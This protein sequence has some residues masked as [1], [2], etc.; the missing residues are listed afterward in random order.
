MVD[1]A[2]RFGNWVDA[3]SA[4]LVLSDRLEADV[5]SILCPI[6]TVPPDFAGRLAYV[7]LSGSSG[8]TCHRGVSV[9]RSPNCIAGTCIGGADYVPLESRARFECVCLL[10]SR[11][12]GCRDHVIISKVVVVRATVT[13]PGAVTTAWLPTIAIVPAMVSAIVPAMVPPTS[14]LPVS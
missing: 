14:R 13:G 1:S 6:Q 2:S 9:T 5:R 11:A 4:R 10:E 8:I 7:A 12:T 3:I